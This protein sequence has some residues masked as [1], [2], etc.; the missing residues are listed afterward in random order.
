MNKSH[1][2]LSNTTDI[3]FMMLYFKN[4]NILLSIAS[5]KLTPFS[6]VL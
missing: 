4:E 6:P 1:Q 2:I 3:F 5:S